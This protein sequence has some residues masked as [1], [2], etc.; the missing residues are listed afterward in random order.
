VRWS[1]GIAGEDRR[2]LRGG[3]VRQWFTSRRASGDGDGHVS[4]CGVVQHRQP[5]CDVGDAPSRL[6]QSTGR[7]HRRRVTSP[8]R[9]LSA[10]YAYTIHSRFAPGPI[11]SHAGANRPISPWPIRS[12]ELSLPG[13]KWPGNLL[14][15]KH[16]ATY[17]RCESSRERNGQGAKGPGS[18]LARVLLADSLLEANLPGSEKAG[19]PI[20]HRH[21]RHRHHASVALIISII[22]PTAITYSMGQIINSVCL[23]VHVSV[24]SH[25]RSRMHAFLDRFSQKWQ[26]GNNPQK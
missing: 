5:A 6:R 19:Y 24:C 21:L 25:Y 7:R 10:T 16:I 3:V 11:R 12:L 14:L 18:E 1:H 2:G 8:P 22:C 15:R 9:H 23:S 20:T 4:T 26:R 13:A 17:T